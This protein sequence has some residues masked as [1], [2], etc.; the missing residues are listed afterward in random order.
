MAF[1]FFPQISYGPSYLLHNEEVSRLLESDKI[2][3]FLRI[4][5]PNLY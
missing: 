5:S 2:C 4:I 3:D 1:D